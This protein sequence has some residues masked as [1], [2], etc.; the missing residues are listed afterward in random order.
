M[1]FAK[2]VILCAYSGNVKAKDFESITKCSKFN[3]QFFV[4]DGSRPNL[5]GHN[6]LSSIFIDGLQF[7]QEEQF[8]N[9]NK[10]FNKLCQ[11][12]LDIFG[13]EVRYDE[14]SRSRH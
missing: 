2:N 4:I 13:V 6:V 12:F 8:D 10:I 5:L 14:R 11:K 3:H 9:V 1:F 7:L